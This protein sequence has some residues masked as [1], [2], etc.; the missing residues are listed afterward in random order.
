LI[1]EGPGE[2]HGEHAL[3]LGQV[4][5]E[6]DDQD[7]IILKLCHICRR[8]HEGWGLA[9]VLVWKRM[10]ERGEVLGDLIP[11]ER[12]GEGSLPGQI[13]HRWQRQEL[14]RGPHMARG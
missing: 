14:L 8:Q 10:E 7:P 12:G 6:D 3:A 5:V 11:S 2:V 1:V 9:I 4:S 13:H